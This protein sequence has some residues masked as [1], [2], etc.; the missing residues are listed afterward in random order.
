MN[1]NE[2]N[3]YQLIDDYLS[4]GL[5]QDDIDKFRAFL[6]SDADLA[7]EHRIVRELQ[8][9][10]SF[11]HKEADLR[12]TLATLRKEDVSEI[13]MEPTAKRGRLRYLMSAVAVAA[14]FLLLFSVY[15]NGEA[16]MGDSYE[17]Y[18]MAEPL[19]LI[20]KGSIEQTSHIL[21]KELQEAYN[22]GDYEKALPLIE[23]YLKEAPKDMDVLLAKGISLSEL[24]RY[25][26]A[27]EAFDYIA[28]LKPRVQKQKWYDAICYLKEGNKSQATVLLEELVNAKAYQSSE[29]AKLLETIN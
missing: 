2:A 10:E 16:T 20:T 14:S 26:E 4:G 25:A 9:S 11:A 13:K 15:F 28:S 23:D 24:E 3:K 1:L 18:A 17:Q 7:L 22:S 12:D 19:D 29:A 21:T 6:Q 5:S 8:E 27:H